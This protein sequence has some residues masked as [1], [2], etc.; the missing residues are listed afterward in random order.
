MCYAV[1]A[2]AQDAQRYATLRVLETYIEH[3][4]DLFPATPEDIRD[5]RGRV[6]KLAIPGNE[7]ACEPWI[8]ILEYI[9]L[10][11]WRRKGIG[12]SFHEPRMQD[13][14]RHIAMSFSPELVQEVE[15]STHE[16]WAV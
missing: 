6:R 12:A 9:Q 10:R 4:F 3:L 14:R 1:G 13:L 15:E 5:P 16:W 2:T 11:N 7:G 8:D